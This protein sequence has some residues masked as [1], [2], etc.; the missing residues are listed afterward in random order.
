V[1]WFEANQKVKQLLSNKTQESSRPE[2]A[3]SR[4]IGESFCAQLRK[5]GALDGQIDGAMWPIEEER[6]GIGNM[7]GALLECSAIFWA[8]D[9]V[10]R[11]TASH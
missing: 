9:R 6:P 3:C 1:H 11:L 8:R 10:L 2:T 7:I 5:S 4:R